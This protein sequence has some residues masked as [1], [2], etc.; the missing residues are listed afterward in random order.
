M[1]ESDPRH[2]L[3]VVAR[4]DRLYASARG[5][6][7]DPAERIRRRRLIATGMAELRRHNPDRL[8][9]V[10]ARLRE[11][12]ADLQRFGIRDRDV[13]QRVSFG[14]AARFVALEGTLALVL[15]P[16]AVVSLIVFGLPY[17]IT[18]QISRRAPDL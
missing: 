18:G 17:W 5:V 6:S 8:A 4:A 12:D 15:A 2:D 9:A 11:C 10:L 14:M 1:V 13:E 7:R 16:L 3:P